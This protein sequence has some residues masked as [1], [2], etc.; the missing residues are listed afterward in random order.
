MKKIAIIAGAL[1]SLM[2]SCESN[3]AAKTPAPQPTDKQAS[4]CNIRF[5]DVD[6]VLNS[7]ILAQELMTEQQREMAALESQANQKQS[8]LQRLQAQIE[9]K[10]RSNGY[11]T[12]E[13]LNADVAGLQKRQDEA[14]QWLNTHQERLARIMTAQQIRLND[15]LQNFLKDFN[16]VYQYDAILDKKA[17]FFKPEL[18][19]T[20]LVIVGLNQRY[21]PEE[22]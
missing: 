6:S 8:E 7:Y 17:G 21:K 13:S 19:I 11:L 10:A 16:A 1:F 2:V 5:I 15:S 18:D 12:Q 3:E 4:A 14:G 20:E 22:K 9:N